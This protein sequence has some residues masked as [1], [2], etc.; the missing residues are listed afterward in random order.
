MSDLFK[1]LL[2]DIGNS[3]IKYARVNDMSDLTDIKCCQH[4]EELTAYISSVN[5]VL[6]SSVGH[7]TQVEEL[8]CLCERLNKSCKVINTEA[9]T[10]GIKCAY[11]KYQT[12]GVDRWLVILAAREITQLPVAVIDLG[13]ANTCDIVINNQ[14]L[15]GW[16]A[17][18]FSLMRESLLSNTQKVFV[19][20]NMP[21]NLEIGNTTENCVNYGCL[22][23]QTGFV[24]MAEKYLKNKYDDYFVLV[25]GGGQN[26]LSLQDNKKILFFPNLV[27]RGLFRL[28]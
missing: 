24:V 2:V 19:D 27:L 17:P 23:S 5:Q 9:A 28:I 25:T 7:V 16:I 10:L 18:G 21:V 4:P 20:T 11:E 6:V 14:H 13:T 3:Q 8:Q 12:L 15:G 1:A 26:S 22:A